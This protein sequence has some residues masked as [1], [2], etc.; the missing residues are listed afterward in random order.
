MA[1]GAVGPKA[2]KRFV[3]ARS[4]RKRADF[5]PGKGDILLLRPRSSIQPSSCRGKVECPLSHLPRLVPMGNPLSCT[6]LTKVQA[7]QVHELR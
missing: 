2:G 5:G 6:M 4:Q 7:T 1:P 3:Q